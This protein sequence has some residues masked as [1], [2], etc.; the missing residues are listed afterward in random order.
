MPLQAE[1]HERIGIPRIGCKP[2]FSVSDPDLSYQD[3]SSPVGYLLVFRESIF[4]LTYLSDYA[5]NRTRNSPTA[6]SAR[7][8]ICRRS[9]ISIT[10]SSRRIC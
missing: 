4:E 1:K 9:G 7:A 3:R 8:S 2:H 6:R 10:P 5:P